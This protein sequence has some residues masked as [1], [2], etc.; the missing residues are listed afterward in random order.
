MK[1]IAEAKKIA[2][3]SSITKHKTGA[4]FVRNDKIISNGWSHVPHYKLR[5][6]RSLHAEMHALARA[7]H[8]NLNGVICYVATVVGKSGNYVSGM[9]CLD[10]A[11]AL[12]AAGIMSVC[13]T[14]PFL[15]ISELDLMEESN[16]DDLKVYEQ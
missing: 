4:I 12:K 2:E 13:F 10:C 6:K 11:I 3:R 7:R 15:S 9:P 8:L 14:H 5:G 16:F 1:Y